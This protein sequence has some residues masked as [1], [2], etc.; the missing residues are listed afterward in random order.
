VPS[1]QLS[2]L[3]ALLAIV[4]AQDVAQR[5]VPNLMVGLIAV[6]G[7]LSQVGS[8]GARGMLGGVLAG[9]AAFAVLLVAWRFGL[10]GGGD[11]KLAAATAIW[12]GPSRL[13]LFGLLTGVA[14]LPVAL[15][16]RLARYFGQEPSCRVAGQ[17]P[18]LEA[19]ASPPQTVPVAVAIALGAFAAMTW[20]SP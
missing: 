13:L 11:L 8:G 7:L 17:G 9:A 16:A 4:C 18:A 1:L 10:L 6:S 2:I 15:V 12:V 14:G 5:R 20:G 3:G 19:A